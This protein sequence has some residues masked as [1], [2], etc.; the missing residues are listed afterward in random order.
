M[1]NEELWFE[2]LEDDSVEENA[3]EKHF[4]LGCFG[5]GNDKDGGL[6]C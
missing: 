1:Q 6:Y 4:S 5:C 2:V 3:E